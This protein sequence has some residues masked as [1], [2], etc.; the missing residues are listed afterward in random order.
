MQKRLGIVLTVFLLAIAALFSGA[1]Q[2][3][4]LLE[5]PR[6]TASLPLAPI[7]LPLYQLMLVL[8][9]A[10]FGAGLLIGWG[11]GLKYRRMLQKFQR[12]NR[13]LEEE[14]RNLRNLP[15]EQDVHL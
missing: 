4:I 10:G 11:S 3:D 7:R 15:L 1:N 2:M 13:Q 8:L 6:L 9:A 12:Q 5:I 14:L